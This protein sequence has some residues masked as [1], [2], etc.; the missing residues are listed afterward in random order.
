MTTREFLN[1]ILTA[2]VSDE[3]KAQA[4]VEI[5]R[6]DK[7]NAQRKSKPSKTALANAPV[8]EAIMGFAV[9]QEQV[10]TAKQVATALDITVQ[11]ASALLRQLADEG[12][13]TAADAKVD[14]HLAKV[15]G[16][17]Q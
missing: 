6:L 17:A 15:Y 10:F 14:K 11:K 12:K 13:L 2:D 7:R 16:V 5:D 3:L 4:Q 1:A 8:K 9:V